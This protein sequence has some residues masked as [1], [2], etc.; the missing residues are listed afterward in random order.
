LQR[1]RLNPTAE[2]QPVTKISKDLVWSIIGLLALTLSVLLLV[3]RL[4]DIALADLLGALRAIPFTGWALAGLA[5]LTAYAAL[6]GYDRLALMHLGHRVPWAFIAAASLTAYAIGHNVGASVISGGVVRYRA[7]RSKGLRPQEIA[8]LIAFCSFTFG[9]AVVLLGGLVLLLEPGLP[10][11]F[12]GAVPE[13]VALAIGALMLV[14]VAIY[15]LGSWLGLPPTRIRGFHLYY[16]RLPVVWRQLV[17][18]PLETVAAAAIIYFALPSGSDPGFIVVLGVFLASFSAA[19]LSHAPGG[20][21]VL[22]V[23]FLLGLPEVPPADLIAALL[24]FRLLYMLLPF[25]ISI[26]LVAWFEHGQW[27]RR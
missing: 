9:L 20:L 4:Q 11:R 5:A 13:S 12:I 17:I 26:V 16:P 3:D 23:A 19:L 18:A 15:L 25:A 1:G 8:V 14:A 7:Y 27:M 24:V 6:A 21:G 10:G 22:E 2:A